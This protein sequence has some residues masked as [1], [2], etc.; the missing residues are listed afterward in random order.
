MEFTEIV[1]RRRMVRNYTDEPVAAESILRIVKAAKTAPS[2]GFS[3]G[4]RMVVVT[5]AATRK[6]IAELGDEPYLIEHGYEPWVSR[7]PVHIV[8]VLRED[9]Y[10]DRYQEPGKLENG[11]EM[12]WPV[13]WWWVDAGTTIML[14]LLAA[15]DEDLGAGLF[16]L[17][18]KA[19]NELLRDHLG[20]PDDQ[21]VVGV[22][23]IGHAAPEPM[24]ERRIADL[25][26]RRRPLQ[27]VVRWEHW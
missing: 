9:D 12:E 3:Q 24:E 11:E 5:E 23:A 16:T 14:L 13:P 4:M 6:K 2:A 10:H 8:V 15:I 7:A 25:R 18:P 22:I 26:R 17:F 19:N 27:D 21:Q 20:M 1:H